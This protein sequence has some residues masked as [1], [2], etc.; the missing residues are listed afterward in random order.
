MPR[1]EAANNRRGGAGE[2]GAA[3]GGKT[4]EDTRGGGHP[5][6]RVTHPGFGSAASAEDLSIYASILPHLVYA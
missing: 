5:G 2:V 3:G 1:E 6:H 4:P